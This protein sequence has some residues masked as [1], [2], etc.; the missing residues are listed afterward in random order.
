MAKQQI[1]IDVQSDAQHL[2]EK[3]IWQVPQAFEKGESKAMALSL[4]DGKENNTLRMDIWSKDMSIDEMKKFFIQS[5]ITFSD[6][7]E[8]ATGD[9]SL[10]DKVKQFMIDVAKQEKVM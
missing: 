6:A 3:I 8:R 1:I 9:K 10:S 5:V 4:W 2:P 7:M